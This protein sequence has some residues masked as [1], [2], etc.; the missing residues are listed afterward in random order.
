MLGSARDLAHVHSTCLFFKFFIEGPDCD[1]LWKRLLHQDQRLEMAR[2]RAEAAAAASA[3][4]AHASPGSYRR[5]Y[6]LWKLDREQRRQRDLRSRATALEALRRLEEQYARR[7]IVG[8][9]S[10]VDE[11]GWLVNPWGV[12]MYP[13][14]RFFHQQPRRDPTGSLL[15]PPPFGFGPGPTIPGF[16]F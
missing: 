10:G 7:M 13:V 1:P 5:A 6:I 15:P 11:N 9:A 8:G 14:P 3:G 2:D 4:D 16:R 12:P